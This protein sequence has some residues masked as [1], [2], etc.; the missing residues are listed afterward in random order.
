MN[1]LIRPTALAASIAMATPVAFAD[2]FDLSEKLS[3]TGFID[4]SMLYTDP[5]G[6]TSS[7]VAGLDQFEIDFLFKFDDK[8]TAQV[9][10]EYH[11]DGAGQI[12]DV[13]QAFFTYAVNDELSVTAGR[14]LS[15]SGWETEEPTGLFQYSGT[16]YAMY[17]YGGYQQG[18]STKYS[19]EDYQVA[20]SIITDPG[21]LTGSGTDMESVGTELMLAVTPVEG[22]TAKA[23]FISEQDTDL[24]NV[25]ASYAVDDLILAVE[26]NTADLGTNEATGF[27]LMANYAWDDFGLTVR[28]HEVEVENAADVTTVEGSAITISPSYKVSEN[29]LIVTE[30]RTDDDDLNGG[31]TDSIAVE[32]LLTF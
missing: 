28:Y 19:T 1:K 24:V 13:E 30:F 8:L 12:T 26:F 27:L 29:L 17:F 31:S 15:Y 32:A 20:L 5:E 18:V 23:F 25:W 11:D 2:G 16:G 9:D 14:F 3:V 10:L 22:L 4:M 21:N 7:T 6:G